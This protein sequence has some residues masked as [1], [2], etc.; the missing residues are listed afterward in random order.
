MSLLHRLL[1]SQYPVIS[2]SWRGSFFFSCRFLVLLFLDRMTLKEA[3]HRPV[4]EF[5]AFVD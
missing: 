1:G 4:F 5:V 2:R 3:L